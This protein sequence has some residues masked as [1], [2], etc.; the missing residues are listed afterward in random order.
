MEPG[1]KGL[2]MSG[3]TK[4][5]STILA[6]TIWGASKETKIV[7]ITMLAMADKYGAVHASIPGLATM[8]RLTNQEVEAALSDLLSPDPYSRTKD[9]EGRRIEPIDGGW[10]VLNHAKYREQI[11]SDDRREYLRIK[12]QESRDRKRESTNVNNP[13]DVC[14]HPYGAAY[15]SGVVSVSEGGLGETAFDGELPPAIDTAEM[16]EALGA[17]L[18][19]KAESKKPYKPAGL[20]A[21]ISHAAKLAQQ[22]GAASVI[23]AMERAASNGWAGW[24][25]PNAFNGGTKHGTGKP[26]SN[27]GPGQRYRG[28]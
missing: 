6:S 9:F 14:R 2:P 11:T 17:W 20:K 22:H 7:W 21:M 15:A 25:Q 26:A 13:V 4:L 24:D 12:K 19:Y 10:L 23:Q 5:F 18:A 16:R 28:E 1:D 3:Y 27:V 8:A